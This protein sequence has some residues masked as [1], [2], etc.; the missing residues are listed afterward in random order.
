VAGASAQTQVLL[1]RLK[2]A[3]PGWEGAESRRAADT[4]TEASWRSHASGSGDGGGLGGDSSWG[5]G[6]WARRR[7]GSRRQAVERGREAQAPRLAGAREMQARVFLG[8]RG[9]SAGGGARQAHALRLTEGGLS[10]FLLFGSPPP[11]LLCPPCFVS[12]IAPPNAQ[13]VGGLWPKCAMS[14]EL[15]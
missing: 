6:H 4:A 2:C 9:S 11:P 5:A 7:R 15:K 13:A 10:F 12:Y 8:A 1:G 3:L 14:I